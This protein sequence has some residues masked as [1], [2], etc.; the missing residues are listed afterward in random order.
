MGGLKREEIYDEFLESPA[1]SVTVREDSE[2]PKLISGVPLGGIGTGKVEICP[3]GALHHLTINNNDVFPI[4][5]MPGTF[6]AVSARSAESKVLKVLQTRSEIASPDMLLN[7]HEIDY[8][9]LYPR[10]MVEYASGDLPLKIKL[11]AFSPVIPRFLEASSLPIAFLV[12]D[13]VNASS[14]KVDGNLVFSWEDVS[15]CWGSKVSFPT[16]RR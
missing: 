5:G 11:T 12:F 15:G 2:N 6:L 1:G 3:D 4:D 16:I 8:R 14:G 7:A 10:C 9:G 13:I